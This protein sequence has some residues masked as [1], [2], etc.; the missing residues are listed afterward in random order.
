MFEAETD[1]ANSAGTTLA[2]AARDF[3]EGGSV[4]WKYYK[5][6]TEH[7]TSHQVIIQLQIIFRMR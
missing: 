1:S 4:E 3:L 7:V 5:M 6:Y 2:G